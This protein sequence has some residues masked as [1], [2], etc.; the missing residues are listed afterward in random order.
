MPAKQG[1]LWSDPSR[2]SRFQPGAADT[3]RVDALQRL[4]AWTRERFALAPS[5]TVMVTQV[6]R[7]LPGFPPQETVVGFWTPDGT[8]HHFRVFKRVEQVL[9]EDVPPAWLRAALQWDGFDC[10]CC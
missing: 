2:A 4:E 7:D 9:P 8:R 10:D 3:A 1:S 5:D 6:A